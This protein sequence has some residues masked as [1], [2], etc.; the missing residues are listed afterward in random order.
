MEPAAIG[1]MAD[2]DAIPELQKPTRPAAEKRRPRREPEIKRPP[3]SDDKVIDKEDQGDSGPDKG[4]P[5]TRQSKSPLTPE[6][7]H[8][9]ARED[10]VSKTQAPAG[11]A[12]QD[13][14]KQG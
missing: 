7:A 4:N 3:A 2:T 14:P 6:D 1:D 13:E 5:L 9:G 8:I 10:Q 11:E 12:F